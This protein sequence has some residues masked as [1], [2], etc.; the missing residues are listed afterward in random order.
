MKFC[1]RATLSTIFLSHTDRRHLP[2]IVKLCPCHPKTFKSIKNRKSKIFTKTKL[3][4]V[5]I[6]RSQTG[7]PESHIESKKRGKRRASTYWKEREKLISLLISDWS[8]KRIEFF[9]GGVFFLE[10]N[11]FWGYYIM[12][13]KNKN[14]LILSFFLSFDYIILNRERSHCRGDKK[15]L[16]KMRMRK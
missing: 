9:L 7:N 12:K 1:A 4:S 8:E 5:Y 14:C 2:E 10:N 11:C 13:R 3:S 15:F 16:G 6:E